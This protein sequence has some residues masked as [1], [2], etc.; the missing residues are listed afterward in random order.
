MKYLASQMFFRQGQYDKAENLIQQ[1]I[2][3]AQI[4]HLKKREGGF[5]RLWGEIHLFHN[6]YDRAI[7]CVNEAIKILDYVG[8][9]HQ[10]WI[11]YSSLAY[12]YEKMG[13]TGESHE[14][15]N[16]AINIVEKYADNLKE[17]QLKEDFLNSAQIKEI[18]SK[19]PH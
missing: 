2:K 17:N 7:E 14:N 5:L 4:Q 10:L 8:N 12:V 15:W 9:P 16:R 1:N 13:R 3:K 18:L 19:H 6:N 11:A